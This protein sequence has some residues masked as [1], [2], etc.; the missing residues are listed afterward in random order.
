MCNR[1]FCPKQEQPEGTSLQEAFV[2]EE[3]CMSV[4]IRPVPTTAG[5]NLQEACRHQNI[6]VQFSV[7]V[8]VA[9]LYILSRRKKNISFIFLFPHF[10]SFQNQLGSGSSGEKTYFFL[11]NE[12]P[13]NFYCCN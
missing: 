4:Q 5:I 6:S 11:Q 9:F 8:C 1:M 3:H 10:Y 13:F 12:Q 2:Y 7:C